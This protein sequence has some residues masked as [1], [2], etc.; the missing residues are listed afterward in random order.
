MPY[1]DFPLYE[2]ATYFRPEES[3][4]ILEDILQRHSSLPVALLMVPDVAQW[5]LEVNI[6]VT[7]N[8]IA[9]AIPRTEEFSARIVV[10]AEIS[11]DEAESVLGLLE[12][13]GYADEVRSLRLDPER[14]TMHLVL[15]ELAHIEN[16]WG[17]EREL[18][19]DKW[20]FARLPSA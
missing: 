11:K 20:A 18:D 12:L 3:R 8:P 16:E 10:K 15:H 17:Q 4:D 9:T 19:C 14:F 7:G 13:C 6:A 2:S 5:A 1:G